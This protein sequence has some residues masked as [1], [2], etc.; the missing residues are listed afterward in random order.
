MSENS[1]EMALLQLAAMQVGIPAI[2]ISYAYSVLSQSGGHIKHI[3]DVTG[4]PLL[5]MSNADV[6][7]AKLGQWELPGLSM[8]A[9][10]SAEKHARV[11]PLAALEAG[12]GEL[13]GAGEE[14]FAAVTP[15]TLAK[16]QFTSGSTN[17]PKGV[18]VTHGM[19]MSN[20]VAISQM[21]PFVGADDRVVDFLPWN[22]TFG[23]N[24]VFNMLLMHGG[25][26][27]I[28]RGNPTP[29]GLDTMVA[30]I[31]DVRP[32]M[33]FGVPR[34]Y[35]AL[36]ARMKTDEQLRTAF[37]SRLKFMF[38]AAAALEQQTFDG[39]QALSAAERGAPVPFFAAWGMTE[40]A[41]DATLPRLLWM[42]NSAATAVTA[43]HNQGLRVPSRQVVS[44]PLA[45]SLV[46]TIC[47]TS[48]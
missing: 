40:S 16:I 30:N 28:D 26:F 19:M 42:R 22:H 44:S 31:V 46:A 36:Y 29:A 25:T 21:W 1:V 6:H 11:L 41:P 17:L 13:S 33:Y 48:P 47:C 23:G 39:M 4:A 43:V 34:S 8:Y 5:V 12:E 3:L 20:Q 45:W 38:T 7:M 24:F 10:A 27:F 15:Q 9:V 32:T 37:F 35:T 18:E 2:P 14:R